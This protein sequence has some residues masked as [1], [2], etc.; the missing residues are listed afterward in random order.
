[1]A[2]NVSFNLYVHINGEVEVEDYGGDPNELLDAIFPDG[3]VGEVWDV[4]TNP[5]F[6]QNGY[7]EVTNVDIEEEGET[8][9]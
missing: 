6:M 2:K 9:T 3:W 5:S 4:F 7:V 1:M 8:A